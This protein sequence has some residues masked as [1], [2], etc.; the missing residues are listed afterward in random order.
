MTLNTTLKQIPVCVKQVK[1]EIE[2]E[3]IIEMFQGESLGVGC[4]GIKT[5]PVT[6][7]GVPDEDSF[8]IRSPCCSLTDASLSMPI[9]QGVSSPRSQDLKQKISPLNP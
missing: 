4:C 3:E 5:R 1:M 9:H 7:D 8:H 2:T 6:D